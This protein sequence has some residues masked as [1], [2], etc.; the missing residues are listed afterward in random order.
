MVT[1]QISDEAKEHLQREAIRMSVRQEKPVSIREA[2]NR[3]LFGE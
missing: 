2:L 1:V 3:L